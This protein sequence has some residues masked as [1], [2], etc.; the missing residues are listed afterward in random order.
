MRSED[1]LDG[2]LFERRLLGS[3]AGRTREGGEPRRN[4]KRLEKLLSDPHDKK[5]NLYESGIGPWCRTLLDPADLPLAESLYHRVVAT[6][7][8]GSTGV[9]EALLDMIGGLSNPASATFWLGLVDL[10]RPRDPFAPRRRAY[11]LAALALLAIVHKTPEAWNTLGSAAR[12]IDAEVRALAVYYI[13]CACLESDSPVP[14]D[15]RDQLADIARHDKSF[16]PRF[17]ARMALLLAGKRAPMDY[18]GGV[19]HFR[20]GGGRGG[21]FSRTIALQS[22]QTLEHLHLAIQDALDWDNDHLY[23]FFMNGKSGDQRYAFACPF[24]RDNPPFT[25]EAIVGELGLSIRHKFIY[26]FDYGDCHEII[27]EVT[28]IHAKGEKGVRYPSVVES[29][30]AAPQQYPDWDD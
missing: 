2:W 25:D 28:E 16:T 27:V 1:P 20:I 18:P 23:S 5:V 22:K 17:Q 30:G 19:Y 15:V 21:V 6:G 26:L 29:H 9:Q 11:A 7:G 14:Q 24:E 4:L 8:S 3:P 12:H 13:G 10:R